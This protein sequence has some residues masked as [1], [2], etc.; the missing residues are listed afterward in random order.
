MLRVLLREM[1]RVKCKGDRKQEKVAIA[2]PL[3]CLGDA[4]MSVMSFLSGNESLK[5]KQDRKQAKTGLAYFLPLFGRRR[6][7]GLCLINSKGRAF[8]VNKTENNRNQ[9]QQQPSTSFISLPLLGE[10]LMSFSYKGKSL[11][12]QNIQQTIEINH[13]ISLSL[14]GR[15]RNGR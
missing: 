6:N 15:R 13:C 5:S 12:G 9:P 1:K 14:F 7:G 2:Y 4:E 3:H 11:E 10:D 8:R